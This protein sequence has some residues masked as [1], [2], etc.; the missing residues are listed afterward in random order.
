MKSRKLKVTANLIGFAVLF[1]VTA[2]SF[3]QPEAWHVIYRSELAL[4]DI[5]FTDL[6]HGIATS[7]WPPVSVYRTSDGGFTWEPLIEWVDFYPNP[8][9]IE[10]YNSRIGFLANGLRSANTTDGG[11]T[12]TVHY[13]GGRK[14]VDLVAYIDSVKMIGVGYELR[15]GEQPGTRRILRSEDGGATWTTV[16]EEV[17]YSGFNYVVSVSESLQVVS[18]QRGDEIWRSTDQ[19]HTWSQDAYSSNSITDMC[20]PAE[21]TIVASGF[22]L[23][24]H[25]PAISKSIDGG[26]NWTNVFLDTSL[27]ATIFEK[28]DFPDSLHGWAVGYDGMVAQTNDGGDSWDLY[29]IDSVNSS[30]SSVCFVDSVNGWTV[31]PPLGGTRILKFGETNSVR[32]ERP[33]LPTYLQVFP[34]YPNPFNSSTTFRFELSARDH[35]AVIIFDVEGKEVDKLLDKTLSAGLHEV[36]WN[37]EYLP[38]GLYFCRVEW[39]HSIRQTVKIVYLR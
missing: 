1:F 24:G 27:R 19:G 7:T 9:G 16:I 2:Q 28:I 37:P 31:D 8:D 32:R 38:S 5:H 14:L 30:L 39:K 23:P 36:H 34:S 22:I 17:T 4:F 15:G 10:F 35:T 33:V 29:F 25:Y 11:E 13:H 20:S 6:R 12:W 21:N 18:V 3:A 26:L